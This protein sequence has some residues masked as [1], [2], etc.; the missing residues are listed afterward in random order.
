M[1]LSGDCGDP[2]EKGACVG[3]AFVCGLSKALRLF[4][5]LLSNEG[6]YLSSLGDIEDFL[7]GLRCSRTFSFGT[8]DGNARSR[9]SGR[10]AC[11]LRGGS[12]GLQGGTANCV[13]GCF[14]NGEVCC[15]FGSSLLKLLCVLNPY[16]L[17]DGLYRGE[18][19]EL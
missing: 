2:D 19:G 10:C 6:V 18:S 9:F 11:S 8:A 3:V 5:G 4:W 16:E 12:S 7:G 1:P 14:F 13:L 15:V 17:L